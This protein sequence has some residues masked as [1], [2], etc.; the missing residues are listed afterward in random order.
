LSDCP[1]LDNQ[2]PDLI[3]LQ[4]RQGI[5]QAH[6]IPI[7]PFIAVEI[8]NFAESLATVELFI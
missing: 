3:G 2:R 6:P 7:E 8:V 1:P 5:V 4:I